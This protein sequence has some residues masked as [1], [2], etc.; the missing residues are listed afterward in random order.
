MSLTTILKNPKYKN[1]FKD[2]FPQPECDLSNDILASPQ[3]KNYMIIGTAFDYVLR[4]HIERMNPNVKSTVW[5]AEQS[6]NELRLK[7]GDY[8]Y[9][10]AGGKFKI[11]K[12]YNVELFRNKDSDFYR[13]IYLDCEIKC[14]QVKK[15]YET[16]LNIGIM[17]RD[18][19]KGTIFLAQLDNVYRSGIVSEFHH[20]NEKDVDDLENL[21]NV[22]KD[23]DFFSTSSECLLNPTF[24]E[25]SKLVGGADADLIIGDTLI[26]IK[27]TINPKRMLLDTWLQII[28]YYIL[29][30]I[31]NN[32]YKIKN[33][34]IYFSRH[35]ML[36]IFPIDILG[37]IDPFIQSFKKEITNDCN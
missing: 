13:K 14:E 30:M 24:R 6:L 8:I 2:R 25:A 1:M 11:I 3:T 4:F 35:G 33:V 5:I 17:T 36:R 26:D 28:G 32:E 18:L 12:N 10:Y 9:N 29:N 20:I 21:I 7:S 15:E 34:G 16:Y 31:N 37:D 22:A 19:L 27:T 23:V